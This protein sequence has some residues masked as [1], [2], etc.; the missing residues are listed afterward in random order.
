MMGCS[1]P[2]SS[3]R[4]VLNMLPSSLHQSH[5][6]VAEAGRSGAVAGVG[7]LLRLALA[8][9]GRPPDHPV[10][11]VADGVAGAP[12]LGGDAGVGGVFHQVAQ[13]ALLDLAGDLGAELE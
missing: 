1:I 12:E 7:H 4:A 8:A 3:Q 11:A 10:V 9:V 2:R 13:L 5:L 6:D